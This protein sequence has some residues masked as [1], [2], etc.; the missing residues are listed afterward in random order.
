MSR[1]ITTKKIKEEYKKKKIA[2]L[3]KKFDE[4][5]IAQHIESACGQACVT[6]DEVLDDARKI[7]EIKADH[8]EAIAFYVEDFLEKVHKFRREIM[9][10]LGRIYTFG[11]EKAKQLEQLKKDLEVGPEPA[12]F[13]FGPTIKDTIHLPETKACGSVSPFGPNVYMYEFSDRV[14]IVEATSKIDAAMKVLSGVPPADHDKLYTELKTV[15]P[16][17]Y[18]GLPKF[19]FL[20]GKK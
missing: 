18:N 14:V 11:I 3:Q 19:E 7:F 13:T 12:F 16:K 15:T 5:P 10:D 20:R 6:L 2:E 8:G 1:R 9:Y 17:V 4:M